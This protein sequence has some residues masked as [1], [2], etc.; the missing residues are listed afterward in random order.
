ML[1]FVRCE[2]SFYLSMILF[3][4]GSPLFGD[5]ALEHSG[6]MPAVDQQNSARWCNRPATSTRTRP[7]RQTQAGSP[8]RLAGMVAIRSAATCVM[9]LPLASAV[10]L[11]SAAQAV[12]VEGAR[13][14]VIDGDVLVGDGAHATPAR[15]AVSPARA[16]DD[17]SGAG[18]QRLHRTGGDVDDAAEVSRHHRV[19]HFLNEFDCDHHV[20]D[21]TVEHLL[22]R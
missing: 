1:S 20:G 11:S 17:R 14:D 5:H 9:L 2:R 19:D 3:S 7:R 21:D 13:Q 6:T 15:N 10:L 4:A 18:E 12:G 22:A 8:K 16:P